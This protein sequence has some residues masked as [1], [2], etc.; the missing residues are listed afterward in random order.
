MDGE[1][2]HARAGGRLPGDPVPDPGLGDAS[3]V[4]PAAAG[5]RGRNRYGRV[6]VRLLPALL[7]VIAVLYD[8]FTPRYFTAGPLYTAAPLVAAAVYS[9][10]G[11]VLT[12]ITVVA[13]VIGLQLRKEVIHYVDSLT[14]L[15]T[16]AT[17]AVLAVFVNAFV[18]RAG[19]QLVS[20][21]E[22][23]EAAQRAVL[24]EPAE[25]IG[26][27]EIAA[28][29]EAAQADAFIGGDLYAVQ[30]SPRGVR[31][32]VGDVRGKGMGAVAAVAVV[33][34]AF[35]EAAEQEATLEAVAQRLE[36]ALAREGT[37][38][39]GLDAFEGFTT[40]V[41]AELPHGDGVVRILNR[42]HPPPLLLY[43]DGTLHPLPARE[44]ALP[45]GM[46][47]L[48]V[49]PDRAEQ[50]PFPAG[51]TLLLYTDGL[52]EARDAEGEFYDP[53]ERLA[54]HVFR[55]PADLL[56]ALAEDVRRHS[57]G[58]MADDMALLAVRRP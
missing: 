8:S 5:R 10:R 38:R 37:R 55:H 31:L 30:D 3:E 19:E 1:G 52:S 13:V 58:G 42:G 7:I 41:L 26:G 20:V 53:H 33:I 50:A 2:A 36:R 40:A 57:G 14:E 56:D 29:Y 9:R 16:I 18:R 48:G 24:P 23:A 51:A 4:P 11:T 47:E 27:F 39:D 43:A 22:I 44:S 15:I 6:L 32:V 35:R 34:G 25:R 45:L 49:W 28:C 12:G 21:R 17:V 46:G 54:G